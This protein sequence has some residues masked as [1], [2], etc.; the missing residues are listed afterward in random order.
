MRAMPSTVPLRLAVAFAACLA[1]PGAVRAELVSHRAVYTMSLVSA[2]YRSEVAQLDGRMVLRVADVCD[3]W[4]LE[5]RI[6]FRI[7]DFSG[8][9]VR[10]YTTFASWE[11]KDGNS[12]RFEQ[13]TRRDGDTIEELSGRAEVTGDRGGVARLSK[14]VEMRISLPPGTVF[15]SQ[16]TEQLI[17]RA[18]A[19][20][21]QF[22]RIVFDGSTLDNPNHVSAFIGAPTK[23]P[24]FGD[25]AEPQ[26][27]WP[28]QLAFFYI[29]ETGPEPDVEL[30]L[31]L[32]ADGVAREV[33]I[34]YGDF[35][36]RGELDEL[37]LL[38]PVRC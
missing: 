8:T 27:A 24:A 37:E 7:V 11:S 38:P 12:F 36:V 32:Q 6:A 28:V 20:D 30:G 1:F 13:E 16:H 17:A 29:E 22:S 14:P 26:T 35:T 3:G 23:L 21:M 25:D 31:L 15:P 34:D 33:E 2:T 4:T 19:G 9:E 5:Q 10:S 18:R